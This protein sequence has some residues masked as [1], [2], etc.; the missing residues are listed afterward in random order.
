LH[1]QLI[2]RRLA[3]A[4]IALSGLY[5][6]LPLPVPFSNGL[7][8]W[9]VLLLSASALARDGLCYIAGCVMFAVT[10]T[11]FVLLAIVGT[12]IMDYLF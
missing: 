12:H 2:Y 5:L 4:L 7:P 1:E 6:V 11:F 8:A 9:T 10:T 3:G